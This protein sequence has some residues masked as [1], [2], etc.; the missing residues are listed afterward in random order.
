MIDNNMTMN[1]MRMKSGF[2]FS[3]PSPILNKGCFPIDRKTETQLNK[4]LARLNRKY[5]TL[6]PSCQASYYTIVSS[7]TK[8]NIHP[9]FID[10]TTISDYDN[11]SRIKDEIKDLSIVICF[12]EKAYYAAKKVEQTFNIQFII[13]KT[14]EISYSLNRHIN[15][16]NQTSPKRVRTNYNVLTQFNDIDKQLINI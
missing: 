14:K 15:S 10:I 9:K 3:Y 16:F 8:E 11:L 1:H 2:I 4:L 13:I 7:Y 6:F 12:G 5:P